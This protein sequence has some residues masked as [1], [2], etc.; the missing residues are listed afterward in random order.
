MRI[1]TVR[2]IS[3]VFFVA[4]FLWFCVVATLGEKFWQ[5]RGWP[6]NL[7][8]DLDPLVALGTLLTTG[9]VYKGLLLALITI[10]AT[11]FLGRVFCGWV[12]PF[13]AMHQFAGWLAHRKAKM[14]VR[15]KLDTYRRA[16]AVK[17]YILAA[18]LGASIWGVLGGGSAWAP[19]LQTGLLDPI[20]LAHR[21][22]NLALMPLVG[23]AADNAVVQ[24]RWYEGA[25]LIGGIFVVTLLL[26]IV[27]PRFFCRIL[28]PLGAL[29]G[30]LSRFAPFRIGKRAAGCSNCR[31]CHSDCE[32]ACDPENTVRTAECLMCMNCLTRCKDDTI[33]Y[34]PQASAAGE[35]ASPDVSRRGFLLSVAGGA[36]AAPLMRFARHDGINRNPLV[37]RPPGAL[38]EPEFLSRCI[39]CGQCMRACPT[40]IIQPAMLQAGV[41][42]VWTPVLNFRIG[43]S[44]CQIN[45]IACGHVCPTAAIRPLTIE[46]KRGAGAYE[47]RGPVRMGLAFVDRNRCLPWAARKP[48]IVCQEVCPVTPKAIRV[49]EA[50]EPVFDKPFQVAESAAQG[51][52]RSL[53]LADAQLASGALSG[54]DHFARIGAT[55]PRRI[56]GNS[57]DTIEIEGGEAGDGP[58]ELV[59]R[60]QRPWVDQDRCIGCGICEHECPVAG[61]RAVR[62]VADGET[63]G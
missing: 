24:A 22:V 44:G 27:I 23:H 2:R 32:G 45:C 56:V 47:S 12:C 41:E 17:Y 21:S 52:N 48:C 42:G 6:V 62:V 10:V 46:E 51:A 30:I 34:R 11:L 7:F 28:C 59:L 40:N 31:L 37:I 43:T 13:G 3:Q 53:R 26:N 9:T 49:I 36:V 8:L 33:E 5:L 20:P 38:P 29:F 55:S 54:G 61:L 25:W 63:R 14:A 58:V 50:F 1:R 39:K 16:Q 19:S 60:V 4:L 15:I 57:T 35:I 18:M